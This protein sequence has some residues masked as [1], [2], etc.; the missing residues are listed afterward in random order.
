[1]AS[2]RELRPRNRPAKAGG[3]GIAVIA[4]S[5]AMLIW[6]WL[7]VIGPHSGPAKAHGPSASFLQQALGASHPHASLARQPKPGVAVAV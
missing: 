5:A 2:F 4:F 1:M 7:F 6:A 3:V